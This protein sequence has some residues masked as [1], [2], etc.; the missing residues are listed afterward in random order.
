MARGG[1]DDDV[2]AGIRVMAYEVVLPRRDAL[3]DERQGILAGVGFL[4]DADREVV[5]LSRH[6]GERF[7]LGKLVGNAANGDAKQRGATLYGL[8]H[9]YRAPFVTVL[10]RYRSRT[11][12]SSGRRNGAVS[13]VDG[14]LA[15]K[16]GHEDGLLRLCPL[17]FREARTLNKGYAGVGH[18]VLHGQA[19][20]T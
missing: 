8:W 10:R 18:A 16:V 4:V 5:H 1:I 7:F 9:Y 17:P 3:A 14:S 15:H 20:D 6:V 12:Y 2:G 11:F 19:D 13:Q